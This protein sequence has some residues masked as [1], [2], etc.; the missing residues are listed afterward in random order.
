MQKKFFYFFQKTTSLFDLKSCGKGLWGKT[1]H[2]TLTTKYTFIRYVPSMGFHRC[3]FDYFQSGDCN[4]IYFEDLPLD[5]K[6][7]FSMK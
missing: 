2:R 7:L 6:I 1:P 4:M 3:I 5:T